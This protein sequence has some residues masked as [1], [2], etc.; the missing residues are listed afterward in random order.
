MQPVRLIMLQHALEAFLIACIVAPFSFYAGQAARRFKLPQITG[1]VVSGIIC[2]PYVLGI[3]SRESVADL[4]IVEGACLGII[5]LAAGA[6][7]HL[8]ELN[9]ARKQVGRSPAGR[10]QPPG[11]A[12]SPPCLPACLPCRLPCPSGWEGAQRTAWHAAAAHG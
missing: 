7:L 8:S 9:K 2:G 4:N 11:G 3:L 12:C 5:G 6:E 10:Q 1:Y